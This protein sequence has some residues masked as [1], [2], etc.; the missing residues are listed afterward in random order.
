MPC[1]S[2][3]SKSTRACSPVYLWN[4][5]QGQWPTLSSK[6]LH[7][8]PHKEFISDQATFREPAVFAVLRTGKAVLAA[9]SF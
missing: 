4:F 9:R 6:K 1:Q 7:T 3:S 8:L 2:R 5:I